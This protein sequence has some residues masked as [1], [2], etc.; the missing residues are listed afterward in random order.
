MLSLEVYAGLNPASHAENIHFFSAIYD[1]SFYII[2]LYHNYSP[3]PIWNE[4]D[5]P[6][7]KMFNF[8]FIN[9]HLSVYYLQ[10]SKK[11]KQINKVN[12]YDICQQV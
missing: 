10:L 8:W 11:T 5:E 9:L 1:T 4:H 3:F 12:R 2:Y 7:K 6:L